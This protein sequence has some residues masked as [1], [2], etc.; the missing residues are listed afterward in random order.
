[1]YN[2]PKQGLWGHVAPSTYASD[3]FVYGTPRSP[4]FKL[5]L[6]HPVL[7]IPSNS[8][9]HAERPL[10]LCI[11]LYLTTFRRRRKFR[12]TVYPWGRWVFSVIPC[13]H[14]TYDC[15]LC[16]DLLGEHLLYV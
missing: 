14:G 4:R 1:M 7:A 3:R 8:P 10:I 15:H 16:L 6:D 9:A 5:D 13:R 11:R 12:F 2:P